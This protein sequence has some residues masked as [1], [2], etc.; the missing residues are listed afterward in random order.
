MTR[1]WRS[2]LPFLPLALLF[3]LLYGPVL[4][5]PSGHA[6][7]THDADFY[8][9]YFPMTQVAF[10][11]WRDG[12]FPLWNPYI[13][14]GMPM[15]PSM[16]IG[17]LYPPNWLHLILPTERAF[18][19]LY[20]LHIALAGSGMWL[21]VRGRGR[22]NE[23]AI[24]SA[25]AYTF[26][27]PTIL[28][29]DMGL[30]SVVYSSA[31][32]PLIFALID[33]CLRRR[34]FLAMSLL[35][36]SLAC[37]FLAGFPMFTLLLALAIPAYLLCFGVQW[38][39][40]FG[41]NTLALL[42]LFGSAAVIALGLVTPQ[43]LPTWQH[44]LLAHRTELG[45]EQATHCS[46]PA[47]NLLTFAVPDA[48]GNDRRC[49]YWGEVDLFDANVYCGVTTLLLA[50]L[51]LVQWRR[52]E[53]LFWSAFTLLLVAFSLGKDSVFYDLC[54]LFLPVVDW[55]RGISR[56]MIFVN[57]ALAVLAGIGLEDSLSVSR[58]RG[59][60]RYGIVVGALAL[61]GFA[62][63]ASWLTLTEP[64]VWWQNFFDWVR[65]PGR[66]VFT[67]FN[68]EARQ[69][70]LHAG[71]AMMA[72]SLSISLTTTA[73]GCF[74][75]L[76][77]KRRRFAATMLVGVLAGELYAF[78]SRYVILMDTAEWGS[79]AR[80]VREALPP[81][82]QPYRVAAFSHAPPVPANRFLYA[83]IEDVGGHENFVI[84]RYSLFLY[85]WSGIMPK[86]Q[87]YLAVPDDH[88]L[89]DV[90]NV[91]Y[92]LRPRG[93]WHRADDSLVR[94]DVFRWKG[95]AFD[96]FRN[97][98]VLPRALLV[99]RV[100]AVGGVESA[101]QCVPQL[102]EQGVGEATC[103][104]GKIGE[105]PAIG[106]ED[107]AR[108]SVAI[109][110]YSPGRIVASVRCVAPAV[111]LFLENFDPGWQATIDGRPTDVLPANVFMTA[112]EVPAGDHEVVLAYR[113]RSFVVGGMLAGLSGVVLLAGWVFAAW[114]RPRSVAGAS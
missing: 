42:L 113:P 38:S 98:S 7:A 71:F 51:A 6:P 22:S 29:F 104:E 63:T 61:L 35:S 69:T 41:R 11:M 19:L 37:Q 70:V 46:F 57:F 18:C 9:Y 59:L 30:T 45:Y 13:Y 95:T 20:V 65:R 114:R 27:A 96:L 24:V 39:A 3:A 55:F 78:D 62:L 1:D 25:I 111:L 97:E 44:L 87:T 34:T 80:A 86:W 47:V 109:D 75:V 49:P 5:A 12:G 2:F 72:R 26:A 79:L 53:V 17:L 108:E 40:P 112:L 110:S 31:W 8:L 101:A 100:Q 23:A 54:F 10:G 74:L 102:F 64:P 91:K 58:R 92:Y 82:T 76:V 50:G 28:H 15:L 89:Y 77:A 4:C 107:E 103:L 67:Q 66:E 90:L 60:V 56:L 105:L 36:L 73:A 16:E 84:E 81:E 83:R 99:H 52:R 14:A 68:G 32:V 48:L 93:Q 33:H 94:P 85:K 21:Y 43:L 88:Q 106:Q